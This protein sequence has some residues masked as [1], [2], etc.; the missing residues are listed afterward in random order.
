MLTWMLLAG[1]AT[2]TSE[3]VVDAA[4][5]AAAEELPRRSGLTRRNDTP[6]TLVGHALE[7]GAKA[8]TAELHGPALEHVTPDFADGRP[9]VVLTV[10]SL[11]TKT[12][13]LETRTF[14]ADASDLDA[15]VEVLVISRDL[16]FAQARFCGAHGIDRILPLSDFEAGDF[17]KAWGVFIEETHL[18]ARTVVVLDGEGTV[19][20]LEI[21]ENVPDEPQYQPALDALAE[22]V[23]G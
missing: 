1:C 10:P 19:T 11:D 23:G 5:V 22:L 6:Y 21:V 16:P 17:G 4:P 18:L 20:Y 2:T 7:V 12:C 15:S 9:R 14:N 3:M 13:S 8:P